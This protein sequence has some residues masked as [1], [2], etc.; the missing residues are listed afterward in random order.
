MNVCLGLLLNV[1]SFMYKLIKWT[2]SLV[3]INFSWTKYATWQSGQAKFMLLI[4]SWHRKISSL[5]TTH[6]HTLTH[7]HTHPHPPTHPQ[8]QSKL[9]FIASCAMSIGQFPFIKSDRVME[10]PKATGIYHPLRPLTSTVPTLP[11]PTAHCPNSCAHCLA[12]T[13][14]TATT[15]YLSLY[16][17]VFLCLYCG[18]QIPWPADCTNSPKLQL[19]FRVECVFQFSL[20]VVSLCMH[21][22]LPI[23]SH[24][25]HPVPCAI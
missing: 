9:M 6:S 8:T 16:L 10:S 3:L 23:D 13:Q 25:I 4:K 20:F 11:T 18:Y 5:C 21:F 19:A 22:P 17:S 7:T 24:P 2:I 12:P 14:A 15:L 1:T